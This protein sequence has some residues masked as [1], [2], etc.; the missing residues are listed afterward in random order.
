MV[1]TGRSD[2][3]R[4]GFC[5]A[6]FLLLGRREAQRP[7]YMHV[8]ARG[9]TVEEVECREEKAKE[10]WSICLMSE[11]NWARHGA[12]AAVGDAGAGAGADPEA[13]VA[14]VM[15]FFALEGMIMVWCSVGERAL[16]ICWTRWLEGIYLAWTCPSCL[17]V[18]THKFGKIGVDKRLYRTRN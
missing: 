17:G 1:S 3:K 7:R 14:M 4:S 16:R 8:R 15:C 9:R 13:M 6:V 18:Y 2:S 10:G 5:G 12:A 11:R